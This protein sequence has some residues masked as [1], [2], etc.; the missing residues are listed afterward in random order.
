MFEHG[1]AHTGRN[2]GPEIAVSPLEPRGGGHSFLLPVSHLPGTRVLLP[3]PGAWEP[4]LCSGPDWRALCPVLGDS[5]L[6]LA[7][8]EPVLPV[9]PRGRT[10]SYL[11]CNR[12]IRVW[13][14]R[15]K[16]HRRCPRRPL[17]ASA[18]LPWHRPSASASP[19]HSPC[20]SS[21]SGRPTPG[22]SPATC[23]QLTH[24]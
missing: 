5:A 11:R 1:R 2:P 12:S 18:T 24:S 4:P 15:S 7:G 6:F 22:P 9:C 23:L 21:C 10:G 16:Q 19:S 14:V 8:A 3:D 17:P 20:A 13:A